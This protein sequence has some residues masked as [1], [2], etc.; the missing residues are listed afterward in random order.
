ML[1]SSVWLLSFFLRHRFDPYLADGRPWVEIILVVH[2]WVWLLALSWSVGGEVVRRPRAARRD[3]A[4]RWD[5]VRRKARHLLRTALAPLRLF[6]GRQLA[7]LDRSL[8]DWND[9]VKDFILESRLAPGAAAE[10]AEEDE[11]LADLD[12]GRFVRVLGQRSAD[13][14]EVLADA[15]A[16][17]RTA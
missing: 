4:A 14:V 11:P 1:A 13:V 6:A 3:L 5:R 15:V 9:R 2:A 17:P 10:L 16:R 8:D 7:W 12:R